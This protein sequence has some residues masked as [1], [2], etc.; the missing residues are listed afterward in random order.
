MRVKASDKTVHK[1]ADKGG[2]FSGEK[3]ADKGLVFSSLVKPSSPGVVFSPLKKSSSSASKKLKPALS[4]SVH[5][6]KLLLVSKFND[7]SD[8]KES[9]SSSASGAG[10]ASCSGRKVKRNERRRRLSGRAA[11]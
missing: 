4:K 6:N 10:P 9:K 2:F 5:F 8:E 3:M 11:S 1:A 7:H